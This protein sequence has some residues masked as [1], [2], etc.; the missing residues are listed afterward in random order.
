MN[1][2]RDAWQALVHLANLAGKRGYSVRNAHVFAPSAATGSWSV[3]L[4][5]YKPTSATGSE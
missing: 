2:E 1:T 4:E 5:E 3:T